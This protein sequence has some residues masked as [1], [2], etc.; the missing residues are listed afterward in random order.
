MAISLLPF[1][2]K[3][4]GKEQKNAKIYES[5]MMGVCMLHYSCYIFEQKFIEL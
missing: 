4:F 2:A 5:R 3:V 1:T